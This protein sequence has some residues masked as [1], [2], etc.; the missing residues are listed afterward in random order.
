MDYT[1]RNPVGFVAPL[2]ILALPLID[3]AYVSVLRLRAGRKIY[4][5]S[6]DHFPLRL[7]RRLGGSTVATVVTTYVAAAVF[8]G[9]GLVVLYLDAT[10]TVI[11]TA[12]VA[13]VVGG[14][15]VWLARVEMT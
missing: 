6:P 10:T 2:F 13:V 5:G 14:V 4:H 8:G 9:L 12:V 3:T 11:L 7:R 15:L 1:D